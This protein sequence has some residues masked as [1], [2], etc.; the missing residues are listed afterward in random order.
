MNDTRSLEDS[1]RRKVQKY[2]NL[3]K[4]NIS[5]TP[6]KVYDLVFRGITFPKD[7]RFKDDKIV[8]KGITFEGLFNHCKFS[9]YLRGEIIAYDLRVAAALFKTCDFSDI[10]VC[11]LDIRVKDGKIPPVFSIDCVMPTDGMLKVEFLHDNTSKND[12]YYVSSL[13]NNTKITKNTLI[14]S[15]PRSSCAK[16]SQVFVNCE[17]ED[18]ISL[19][20]FSLDGIEKFSSCDVFSHCSFVNDFR[21]APNFCSDISKLTHAGLVF[22]SCSIGEEKLESVVGIP[23]KYLL[24]MSSQDKAERLTCMDVVNEK[25]LEWMVLSPNVETFEGRFALTVKNLIEGG[26]SESVAVDK[27]KSM[28]YFKGRGISYARSVKPLLEKRIHMYLSNTDKNG[29]SRYNIG[30]IRERLLGEGFEIG[31]IEHGIIEAISSE[32][33]VV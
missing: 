15:L 12:K 29:F 10:R 26:M 25:L 21:L 33:F 27:A 13:I 32:Y 17:F 2:V 4:D 20:G 6:D 18:S 24:G 7:A 14:A 23:E 8:V 11:M 9:G 3:N 5:I 19:S 31:E 16:L 22:V 1:Y 30:E 28:K